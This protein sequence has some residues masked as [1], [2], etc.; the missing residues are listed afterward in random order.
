MRQLSFNKSYLI[1]FQERNV[2]KFLHQKNCLKRQH[3]LLQDVAFGVSMQRTI[4]DFLKIFWLCSGSLVILFLKSNIW[5]LS[6]RKLVLTKYTI[7]KL[8]N[9]SSG[10]IG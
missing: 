8:L 1:Y 4:F 3:F 2:L 5:T 7:G 9:F 10:N 6:S